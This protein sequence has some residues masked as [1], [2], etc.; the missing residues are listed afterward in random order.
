MAKVLLVIGNGFDLKC[1]L[2]SSFNDYLKSD[3]YSPITEKI[4]SIDERLSNS[5]SA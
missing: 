3:Y 2:K 4:H 1:G 5:V